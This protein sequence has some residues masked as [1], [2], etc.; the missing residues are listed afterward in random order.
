MY[1]NIMVYRY[2]KDVREIH[3]QTCENKAYIYV[4]KTVEPHSTFAFLL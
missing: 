1:K 2:N 3:I 4:E